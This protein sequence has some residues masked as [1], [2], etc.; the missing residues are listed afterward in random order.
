MAARETVGVGLATVTPGPRAREVVDVDRIA[1]L[2]LTVGVGAITGGLTALTDRLAFTGGLG[3]VKTTRLP[4]RVDRFGET[5]G[6][7]VEIRRR[8]V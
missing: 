4:E 8:R 5:A 1:V 3:A 2:W 6:G 7:D